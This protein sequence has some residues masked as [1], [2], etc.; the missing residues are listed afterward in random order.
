MCCGCGEAEELRHQTL[1]RHALSH[2]DLTDAT[3]C[4]PACKSLAEAT[5]GYLWLLCTARAASAKASTKEEGTH[6][7]ALHGRGQPVGCFILLPG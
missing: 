2:R 6:F 7:D 3:K 4:V 1:R 5:Q